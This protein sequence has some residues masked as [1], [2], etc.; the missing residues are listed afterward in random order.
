MGILVLVMLERY[1]GCTDGKILM[2]HLTPVDETGAEQ[3]KRGV[4]DTTG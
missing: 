1:L 4:R 3:V 2:V